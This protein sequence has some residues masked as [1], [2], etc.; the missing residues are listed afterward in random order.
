[1]K[2]LNEFIIQFV[3]LKE[4]EHY[5]EYKIDKK[6]FEHFEYDEFNDVNVTGNVVLIKKATLLELC[7]KAKGIVNV[8][9]DITNEPYD[10]DIEHSFDLVVNFGNE[11]NN[12][13]EEI[14]IIPHGEYEIN[15]A[16]Y[17]YE[18]IILSMP[19]RRIHPGIENGTLNSEM[20]DKLEELSPKSLEDKKEHEDIDPRW[21]I[22]KKLLTDK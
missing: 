10:Q 1:M 21:N 18:L 2:P 11:F 15:I 14:L 16:Q 13:N 19:T 20:L 17:I 7:F 3:G 9:C 4:G 22:L 5:F 8:F 12:E 6:F